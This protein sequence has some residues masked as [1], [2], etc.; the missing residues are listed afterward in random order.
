MTPDHHVVRRAE[1]ADADAVTQVLAA[2]FRDDPIIMWI[3]PLDGAE[4]AR[5]N[6]G[7]FRPFVDLALAEGQVYATDDMSGVALWLDVDVSAEQEPDGTLVTD[8]TRACGEYGFRFGQLDAL[9]SAHHPIH[10]S[11]AY[12][13]FLGVLPERQG[14]G[15]GTTLLCDRFVD[16]D[17]NHRPAYLESSAPRNRQLYA[18]LGFDTMRMLTLPDGPPLWPMWRPAA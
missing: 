1:A 16:L 15:I 2:S 5:R 17:Q 8:V 12:L 10:E 11:H 3:F 14:Q 4:R 18:R 13:M 7:F 6:T 9:F